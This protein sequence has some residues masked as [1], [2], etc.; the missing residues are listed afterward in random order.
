MASC[1]AKVREVVRLTQNI[2]EV[3][4]EAPMAARAFLP[5][6]FYRLQNFETLAPRG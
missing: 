5:G 4:V 6:Q 2:V 1:G 3:I